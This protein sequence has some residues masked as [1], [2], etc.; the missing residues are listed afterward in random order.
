VKVRRV[1]VGDSFD[2]CF[3]SPR[4]SVAETAPRQYRHVLSVPG[5]VYV[6]ESGDL[7]RTTLVALNSASNGYNAAASIDA[8]LVKNG[9][10]LRN[11]HPGDRFRPLHSK[12]QEKLKRLF[13]ENK[14][15]SD[16]RATW[17]VLL[18]GEDIVWVKGFPVSAEYKVR[19]GASS[20]ILIEVTRAQESEK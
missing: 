2:L 6:P 3:E 8:S 4:S 15:P 17:P 12:R 19:V 1:R 9:L 20:M 18:H 14:V 10:I 11:W 5:E 13:Q 7:I 16:Q